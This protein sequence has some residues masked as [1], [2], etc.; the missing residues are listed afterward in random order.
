MI[1][2]AKSKQVKGI[3]K[4]FNW[5]YYKGRYI[6]IEATCLYDSIS[7][8]DSEGN[9]I[10]SRTYEIINVLYYNNGDV[11]IICDDDEIIIKSSIL[12]KLWNKIRIQILK[13]QIL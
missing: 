10:K 8:N 9:I 5:K 13:S 4:F 3:C 12:Q 1:L 2:I 11:S 7:L 6:I